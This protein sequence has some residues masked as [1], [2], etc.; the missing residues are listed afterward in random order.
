MPFGSRARKP[1]SALEAVSALALLATLAGAGW[2]YAR[3][4]EHQRELGA[5]LVS[6][7]SREHV[8]AARTLVVQGADPRLCGAEGFTTAMAA[9]R[10]GDP[11]LLASVLERGVDPNAVTK[12]GETA[13]IFA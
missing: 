3:W 13:L 5:R 8:A 12:A 11:A 9:T 7:L 1:G 2:A 10:L 4:R 6:A